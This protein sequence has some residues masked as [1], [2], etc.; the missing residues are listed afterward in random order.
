[1]LGAHKLEVWAEVAGS[2]TA[3]TFVSLENFSVIL[4]I[5]SIFFDSFARM[6]RPRRASLH[7]RTQAG[8][9]A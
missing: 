7:A 8:T 9:F 5:G 6:R 2:F 1:L 4:R 3:R